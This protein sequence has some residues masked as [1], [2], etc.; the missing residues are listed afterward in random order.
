M[1]VG[2]VRRVTFAG[3]FRLK[4]RGL[5][6]E[7]TDLILHRGEVGPGKSWVQAGEHLAFSDDVALPYVNA[8]DDGLIEGL[9]D[10]IG[11]F[12]D[13]LSACRDDFV[14][15]DQSGCGEDRDDHQEDKEISRAR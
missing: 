6:G 11:R 15:A 3:G 8:L 1:R 13:Q 4:A 14:D 12:G 2:P 10:D 5:G 9:H 7:Q